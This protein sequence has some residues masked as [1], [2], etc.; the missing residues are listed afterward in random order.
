MLVGSRRRLLMRRFGRVVLAKCYQPAALLGA[1]SAASLLQA[2]NHRALDFRLIEASLAPPPADLFPSMNSSAPPEFFRTSGAKSV[3]SSHARIF[4]LVLHAHL[5]FVRHPEHKKFLEEC[6]LFEAITETYLP[7]LQVL[8]GWR[9][10]GMTAPLTLSL[11][12]TLCAMLLDP[13]LS[14]VTKNISTA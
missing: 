4:L 1:H 10:D 8:D 13:L 11:S 3:S 5:P 2:E 9:R 12:P 6:W 7:L 14:R